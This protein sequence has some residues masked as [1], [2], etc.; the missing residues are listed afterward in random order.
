VRRLAARFSTDSARVGCV[1][2]INR[3]VGDELRF[4]LARQGRSS[5]EIAR[6]S[7]A[8]D[9]NRLGHPRE[10]R[11]PVIVVVTLDSGAQLG[12]IGRVEL[13]RQHP[14]A[15]ATRRRDEAAAGVGVD[16]RLRAEQAPIHAVSH[17]APPHA[18]RLELHQ[19]LGGPQRRSNGVEQSIRIERL[20]NRPDGF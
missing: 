16:G 19:F 9:V 4:N 7:F 6:E 14:E 20:L 1:V 15:R 12:L 13:N 10:R 11:A 17:V 3:R 18:G 8:V 2:S 5:V